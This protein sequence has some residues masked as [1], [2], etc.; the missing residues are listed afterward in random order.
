MK[1]R[2]IYLTGKSQDFI[3]EESI[4]NYPDFMGKMRYSQGDV[5]CPESLHLAGV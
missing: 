2:G 3:D 1:T 5:T 4:A